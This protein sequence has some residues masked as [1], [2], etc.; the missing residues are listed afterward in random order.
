[1]SVVACGKRSPASFFVVSSPDHSSENGVSQ[2]QSAACILPSS[3]S[4]WV[5]LIVREMS[6]SSNMDGARAHATRILDGLKKS[7]IN[8]KLALKKQLRAFTRNKSKS[9]F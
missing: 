2:N 6:S 3:G 1:M 8:H 7:I 5:E 9:W 4:E